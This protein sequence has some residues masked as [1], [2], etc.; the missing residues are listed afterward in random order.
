MW[1]SSLQS[2]YKSDSINQRLSG[3]QVY[4]PLHNQLSMISLS[5][6]LSPSFSPPSQAK[7]SELQTASGRRRARLNGSSQYLQFTWKADLVESWISKWV[8]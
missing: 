1:F 5:P 8:V 3:I 2:N 7:V 6:S 4:H